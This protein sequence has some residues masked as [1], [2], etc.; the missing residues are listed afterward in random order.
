[1][2][3]AAIIFASASCGGIVGFFFAAALG[4]GAREDERHRPP[5]RPMSHDE[6]V[7]AGIKPPDWYREWWKETVA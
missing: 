2:T 6:L 3:L 5:S 4:T 1:M 7:A